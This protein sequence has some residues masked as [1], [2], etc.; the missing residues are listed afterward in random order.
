MHPAA[1]KAA[2]WRLRSKGVIH[3]VNDEGRGNWRY[4]VVKQDS[5]VPELERIWPDERLK[6][7]PPIVAQPPRV[8]LYDREEPEHA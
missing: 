7:F 3:V 8:H 2:I 5:A 4:A 6:F 1:V